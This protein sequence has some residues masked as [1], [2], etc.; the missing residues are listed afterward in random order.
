MNEELKQWIESGEG[1][2]KTDFRPI[3]EYHEMFEEEGFEI[4]N[5]FSDTNGWQLDFWDYFTKDDVTICL[6]GSFYYGDFKFTKE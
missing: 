1:E 5:E 4:N 2:F 6:S 3:S